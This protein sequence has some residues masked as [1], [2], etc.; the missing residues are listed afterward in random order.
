MRYLKPTKK[1][2]AEFV[3][4][5]DYPTINEDIECLKLPDGNKNAMRLDRHPKRGIGICAPWLLSDFFS[6]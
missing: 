2:I 3:A 4:H 1:N 5:N 6:F